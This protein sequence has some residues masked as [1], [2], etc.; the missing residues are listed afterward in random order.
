MN[1]KIAPIGIPCLD[2][3]HQSSLTRN[4][5]A[6]IA[7]IVVPK[8]RVAR[9][10]RNLRFADRA[11]SVVLENNGRIV[12]RPY[13][14]W[15]LHIGGTCPLERRCDELSETEKEFA[16]QW[17]PWKLGLALRPRCAIASI[18]AGN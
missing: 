10:K 1:S 15:R 12:V 11:P 2:N 18:F 14:F 17:F 7:K 9:R 5:P 16:M 8:P 4:R 13:R 6:A 3:V